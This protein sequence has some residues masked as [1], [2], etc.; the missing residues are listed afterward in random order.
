MKNPFTP[1]KLNLC[2]SVNVNP[3]KRASR[4][5]KGL[6][7]FEAETAFALSLIKKGYCSTKVVSEAKS[8]M[9]RKSGLLEFWTPESINNVGGLNQLKTF[10]ANRAK[11]FEPGNDHLPRPRGVILVGIPG[12][13]KSLTCKAT[14]NILGW[15][16]IRLDIGALKGSLS[17]RKS[18]QKMRSALKVIDAFGESV[19]WIDEIEKA[20]AGSRSSGETDAGTTANMFATFLTW[21]QETETSVMVMAT[22]NDISKLPPELVRAG[23]F[24]ATFFVDVP[25]TSER[26]EIIKIMNRRYNANIPISYVQKLA[27][28]TGAEIEQLAKDSLYDG[29]EAAFEAIVPLSRTM[30]EDIQKLKD[31]AK[32]RARLANTPEDQPK[33]QRK[34]RNVKKG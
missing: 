3:N 4:V 30:R 7:E 29:L 16:L 18:E 10:I 2:K 23:R 33:G 32:N 13:G 31:W 1:F 25:T 6:T 15:P 9:I 24:D 21:M 20:F 22:A 11:A 28:Y 12:T 5:A 34:L 19:I 27:G 14:A 26:I 17:R 8:Q